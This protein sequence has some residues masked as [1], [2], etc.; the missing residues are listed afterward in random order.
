MGKI[1]LILT[2]FTVVVT[3][4]SRNCGAEIVRATFEA[5]VFE[6]PDTVE[7]HCLS[8]C[9]RDPFVWPIVRLALSCLG[10]SPLAQDM[11]RS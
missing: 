3:H 10:A 8:D 6:A 7:F 11:M 9:P 2:L 5:V 1:C 4:H